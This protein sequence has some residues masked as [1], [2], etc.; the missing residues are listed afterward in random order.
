M[1]TVLVFV[2]TSSLTLCA[3]VSP[4]SNADEI[5]N[6]VGDRWSAADLLKAYDEN[7]V[8]AD[9]RAKGR[10]LEVTGTI[11]DIGTDILGAP[12]ITMA[13]RLPSVQAVFNK[14]F[15]NYVA[16]LKKGGRVTVKCRGAGKLMNVLLQDCRPPGS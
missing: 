13:G 11:E 16:G 3:C 10:V 12:Y 4:S 5:E 8:A 7:E 15:Q 14:R 9:Q 6:A 1:R 2:A